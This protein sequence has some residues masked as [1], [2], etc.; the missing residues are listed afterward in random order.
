MKRLPM[1]VW[2]RDLSVTTSRNMCKVLKLSQNYFFKS[3]SV[4]V[5]ADLLLWTISFYVSFEDF[6]EFTGCDARKILFTSF[7]IPDWRQRKLEGK[8][9]GFTQTQKGRFQLLV[10]V[11]N[12]K[13]CYTIKLLF[14]G[15]IMMYST[16]KN[17]CFF[18]DY[19]NEYGV[20]KKKQ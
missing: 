2:Y 15:T 13:W 9:N 19:T 17:K 1:Q 8:M 10:I 11:T 3:H 16:I 7:S 20:R 6:F 18:R 14:Y 12:E 5:S 4:A